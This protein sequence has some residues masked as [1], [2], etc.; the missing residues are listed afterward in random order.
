VKFNVIEEKEN[1][2]LKR[3]ELLLS[4]DYEGGSTPSKAEMQK[5]LAEQLNANI[6]NLEISKVLSE[7]G[8]TRGKAWVKIWEEKKIPLYSE[9]KKKAKPETEQAPAQETKPQEEVKEEQKPEEQKE[10]AKPEKKVEEPKTDEAVEQEQK[11]E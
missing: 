5:I 1:P 9:A 8:L 11:S 6:E 7:I 3:K 2:L 10:E 4:I